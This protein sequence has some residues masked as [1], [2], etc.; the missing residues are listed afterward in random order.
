[1]IP[2]QSC[3]FF[4]VVTLYF[5]FL[6]SFLPYTLASPT[7]RYCRHDQRDAL[8][9]FKHEFPVNESNPIPYDASLS[10]WNKSIDC[11]SWEGVTCH[12]KS[13][14]VI[15]LNLSHV[16]LNNS[17]KPN[18]GLFKLQHLH[19][20]TLSNC[21]LY[22]DIP[23]S[24]GNL[25]RLTLLDLSYNYFVGQVPPSIGNLSHLTILD[26]WDNKLVGQLPAS[27]G[28]LTQ[29]EY[30]ILSHNKFNGNIPFTFANLTKLF[31]ISL[32]NN[33]FETLPLDMSGFQNLDYF[34]VGANSFSGT[35]PKSLFTIP[36]LRWVSFE[37]NMFK[38]PI[39]FR[40][41]SSSSTTRLQYL[42]L[43]E[44]DLSFN[45]LNGSFP[46]FL[47]TIP[48]LQWVNLEGNQ[49]KGPVDFGNMSSSSSL[50]FLNLARNEFN[51]SIP[52]SVSQYHN[53]EELHLS[54][55]NFI[56]T[57]PRS[58][59][60][61]AKLE[62]F[63]LED[64]NMVGEVPSWLWRL[65][66]VTLSNNSFN[67]FEESSGVLDIETQVQWLDLSSNSFQGPFPHWICKLRSLEI[68]IMSNNRFNGSI[69]PC[70]SNATVSLTDLLLRN[71]SFSGTLPDIFVN[72]TKLLSLDVSRNHLDGLLPKS[73]IH[74]KAMQLLNV[75][76]NK[77]KDKFPSWLGSLPSLHVLILRS[78][79]F[80]GTLYQ[81]P[82]SIGFQSLRVID[83]SHNDLTGTLPSFY[84]SSWREM[85]RLTG[86]DGNFRLS[87]V[88]YMGKVL[89]ATA[90]F[91]DSMEIV[92]KGVETEFKRINEDNKI[93]NFAGNRFSGNIPESIGL[94]E[95]LRH[96]NLSSNVF[97][98][99][100]P[101]SLANLTKLEALDL[102]QNQ[103]SGQIPQEL[104]SLSF[105]STMNFSYNF[106]EGP[107]P[108][109]TQFQ[110]QNCSSFMENPKLN[111]LEEICRETRVPSPTPQES[112][113]LSETE[114][115]VINWIA[116]GI[117]YGPGVFCGLV[118]G[119]IF[120][121]HK[122]E[123]W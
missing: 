120:L 36:S 25:F 87:D 48:T 31:V 105:M 94:L 99:N 29:L 101:Q 95:E 7:F 116:A 72:A 14:E 71:N 67:S 106:L 13:G 91:V 50:K 58:L 35:L 8:L 102:S 119:H 103:L 115:Q 60:K 81:P 98:G 80:Y 34:N 39:E 108:K 93:I 83:I 88:P 122:H 118:I 15:S 42:N 97:S 44:L 89:N 54:F 49:L 77:I 12:A 57:I 78:N 10:S 55:N 82:A 43:V 3:Y 2:S 53:L 63:C 76:S 68:L 75:R 113:D 6:V 40:N 104:G 66:M 109:G 27:I 20:L 22:G 117:A 74:C 24:L 112:K 73:L 62:Y 30:M 1:M 38:G 47:L 85:S 100:I 64:N 90:F 41:M 70:L 37:G 107:V 26:L 59:S 18:S 4:S 16:P 51:G 111:G 32:Y 46:A 92:N 21:S 19:N 114:E 96:L 86:E 33:S 123:W 9:E 65:T 121:S 45:N 23:S 28:N 69:P 56:G 79:E 61:L 5:F 17:V 11:C 110:R 84:F 52:E